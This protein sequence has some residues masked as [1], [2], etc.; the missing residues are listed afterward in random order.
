MLDYF[1]LGHPL[2][3]LRTRYALRARRRI[4]SMFMDELSPRDDERVLDLGVTPD[5]SLEESNFFETMYPWRGQITAASI[6]D[7]RL[8]EE[9][10]PG[11]RFVRVEAGT[12]PFREDEFDLMF[13][14]AVLEHV[15]DRAA[16]RAFVR[17]AIR[18][19][20]RFFFTTPNRWYPIEF[21]TLLPCLH[22]LPQP[23][24]Q[25]ALRALG[26]RF[27]ART[28]NLNLLAE[29]DLRAL[30]SECPVELELRRVRLFGL[31]SNLVAFGRKTARRGAAPG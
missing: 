18:V 7:A 4:M 26:Y 25:A 28:E 12:L 17:E 3:R 11:V 13:C 8:L 27:L 9:R 10:Y 19:S 5:I 2:T 21:H 22:W 1:T 14:S 20:R 31:A 29:R 16:Q 15:G 24:H 23:A 6:E 30:F